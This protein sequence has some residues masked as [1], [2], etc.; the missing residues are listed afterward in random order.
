MSFAPNLF[1]SNIKA[2][3]GLARPNR[4][5]VI[6]PIPRYINN[7]IG[8]S[9]FEQLFN[10]PN[11]IFTNASEILG[12]VFGNEPQDSQSKT[13][14]ASLSRYLALQCESAELPGKTL[15]TADV[16]IYGPTFKVPYQSQYTDT[17]LTFLCTNEFYERKLFDRW[18]EAI[19]PSDTNNLRFPKDEETRYMT[20]IKIIQYD[21][22]IKQ[23]Y[24]VE[25]I[26]AF[27]IGVASQQLSW[28]DDGVH[29]LSVQFAY[30]KYKTIYDGTYDLTQAA[31]ALFGLQ[32]EKLMTR[33]GTSVDQKLGRI[34]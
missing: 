12:G 9:V 16:K 8:N 34:F 29:R 21:E 28:S 31:A 20:N 4:F 32:G 5:Q 30:Q 10:L 14:N 13:S 33:L 25:L 27:P 17:T 23:I 6:L 22:F 2:K 7:F 26:D 15:N 24:A 19:M 3:D 11:T 1:L 18:M